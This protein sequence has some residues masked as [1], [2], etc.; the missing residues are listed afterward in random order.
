MYLKER[1]ARCLIEEVKVLCVEWRRHDRRTWIPR[2][3]IMQHAE[4]KMGDNKA[5]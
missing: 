1:E 4:G 2:L 3:I 5:K